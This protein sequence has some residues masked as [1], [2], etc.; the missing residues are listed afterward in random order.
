VNFSELKSAT[1]NIQ[2]PSSPGPTLVASSL[3][4]QAVPG[5]IYQGIIIGVVGGRGRVIRPLS[6]R[7]PDQHG[8]FSL[9]LPASARGQVVKFWES[10]RQFFST[11]TA[12][13]GGRVDPAVYPTSLA[14]DVP[15]AL[16]TVRLPR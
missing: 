6:A 12:R 4:P 2:L 8:R 9:V 3:S 13:P 10:G 16:A 7:W 15:Q 14:S 5:A 1:L 11:A